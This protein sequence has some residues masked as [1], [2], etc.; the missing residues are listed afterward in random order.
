MVITMR[1]LIY[2]GGAVGLGI[3][4][5]LLKAQA[6]VDIIAGENTVRA[7]RKGGLIKTGIFGRYR[8]GAG[9]LK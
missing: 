6:G 8:A 2:G 9:K 1:V 3:A 4:S 7:L 5:C